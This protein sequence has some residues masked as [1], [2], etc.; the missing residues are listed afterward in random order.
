MNQDCPGKWG[1]VFTLLPSLSWAVA[2]SPLSPF[3]NF[4]WP[5]CFLSVPCYQKSVLY[6]K[7][8][9]TS[10]VLAHMFSSSHP[11][12]LILLHPVNFSCPLETTAE[13][14]PLR[15]FPNPSR[16]GLELFLLALLPHVHVPGIRSNRPH[17]N[18]LFPCT[19]S[20]LTECSFRPWLDG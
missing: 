2:N 14:F 18:H 1:H 19:S 8:L 11:S 15:V 20:P 17:Y 6:T 7:V 10:E 3:T 13:S 5:S 9:F 4:P 12:S 16:L